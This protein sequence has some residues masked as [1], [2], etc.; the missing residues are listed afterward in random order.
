M[1]KVHSFVLH[2]KNASLL[3][4]ISMKKVAVTTVLFLSLTQLTFAQEVVDITSSIPQKREEIKQFIETKKA[5]LKPI[6]DE[7]RQEIKAQIVDSKDV[8]KTQLQI[9]A[10]QR[11]LKVVNSIFEVFEAVLVKFEGIIVR[12]EARIEKLNSQDVDTAESQ[13]LLLQAKA[14]LKDTT[15]L[16]SATKI[17]LQNAIESEISKDQIK[18]SIETC[19]KS[20]K[21]TQELLVQVISSLKNDGDSEDLLIE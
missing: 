14:S 20:L 3:Y 4:H 6:I 5:E 13:A 15:A 16:I 9:L 10:Q 11:V 8:Q 7:K 19:K 21:G 18:L 12:I 2:D 17:E 1:A